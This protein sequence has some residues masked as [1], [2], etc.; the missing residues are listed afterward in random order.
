MLKN[1]IFDLGGV[2]LDIEFKRTYEAFRDL[3]INNAYDPSNNPDILELFMS[4]EKGMY[5]VEGFHKRF[6]VMTGFDGCNHDLDHALNAMIIGYKRERIE[7]VQELS[8]KYNTYILS[9]T[10]AIHCEHYNWVLFKEFEIKNLNRIVKKAYYSHELGVRKPDPEIYEKMISDS[11]M[12]AKESLFF[13]DRQENLD[14][15][16]DLGFEVMLVDERHTILEAL[17][18]L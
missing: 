13:D 9:N 15:A 5:S 18:G 2:L 8:L 12:K 1:L 17:E 4:L 11:G 10:N 3:G 16:R 14:T 7:R 6:R